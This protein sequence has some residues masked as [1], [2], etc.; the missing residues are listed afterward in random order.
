M[1][2]LSIAP[3]IGY[4]ASIFLI[5]SL[6]VRSDIK[7]RILNTFGC[8]CFIVYGFAF[9]AWPVILTNTILL[10]INIFYLRK[11]YLHR[12]NFELVEIKYN[13]P[14]IEKFIT[15]YKVDISTFYPSFTSAAMEGNINFV[16]LRD[17]VIANIFSAKMLDNGDAMVL[18]NYAIPKYRDYKVSK[19]LFSKKQQ[20]LISKGVKRILY[21]TNLNEKYKTYFR[22]MNFEN[23]GDQFFKRLS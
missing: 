21:D 7:F 20:T 22:V 16:V 18:I 14:L 19:F 6:S 12:E 23:D 5:L 17:L 2:L 1:N 3:Y 10:F 11:L 15:F 4:L 13:E 8:I 9:N